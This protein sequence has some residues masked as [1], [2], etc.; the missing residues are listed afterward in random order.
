VHLSSVSPS[1][2]VKTKTIST[3][4]ISLIGGI[5]SS[6]FQ[7]GGLVF[8]LWVGLRQSCFFPPNK[9]RLL[10]LAYR[11]KIL[12]KKLLLSF[13]FFFLSCLFLSLPA[14]LSGTALKEL[15]EKN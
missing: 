5:N 8:Q 14:P 10:R 4:Y 15:I 12:E 13:R 11:F 7:A 9:S 2:K 6:N 1:H 3:K